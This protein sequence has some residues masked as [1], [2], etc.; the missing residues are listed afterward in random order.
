ML[1][2]SARS[3]TIKDASNIHTSLAKFNQDSKAIKGKQWFGVALDVLALRT[4]AGSR[5]IWI[6]MPISKFSKGVFVS[7]RIG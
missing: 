6:R 7:P 5:A 4:F 2:P 3:T 1:D